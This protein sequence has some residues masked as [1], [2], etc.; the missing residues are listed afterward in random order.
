MRFR[1][2]SVA[3]TIAFAVPAAFGVTVN[4]TGFDNEES[5]DV[6]MLGVPSYSGAAGR[7]IGTVSDN[8]NAAAS[9]NLPNGSFKSFCAEIT[10][11]AF[12]GQPHEY[13]LESGAGYF[14]AQKSSDLS[15]LFT[16]A[17]SFVTDASTSAAF[18]AAIWEIVYQSGTSYDLTAGSFQ[19]KPA[20]ANDPALVAAF[21][22][23][24]AVLLNL[25]AYSPNYSVEVLSNGLFQDFVVVTVPEPGTYALIAAGLAG[26]AFVAR[27]RRIRSS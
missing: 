23:I 8:A 7:F 18:Q 5:A 25:G 15:R 14:G 22:S 24:N 9:L 12:F 21:A 6:V 26:L 20:N 2:A 3:A 19:G 1:T 10:Q 13:A 11:F 27:R 16:A 17:P 4:I